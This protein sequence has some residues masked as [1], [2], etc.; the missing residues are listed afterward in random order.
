MIES[1]PTTLWIEP[2]WKIVWSNKAILPVLWKLFPGHANL[3]EASRTP[4]EGDQV[5]KPL[6]AREGA[7]VTL[8]RDG[9]EAARSDGR[10]GFV[11]RRL[12]ELAGKGDRRPV[13]GSW[14]VDG[15]PAGLGIREDGPITGNLA[16]FVPHVIV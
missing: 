10:Y 5:V 13:F 6:L 11:Y 7:N 14:V 4:L 8:L 3:L 16:R 9:R 15:Q 1:L 12:F 2:I